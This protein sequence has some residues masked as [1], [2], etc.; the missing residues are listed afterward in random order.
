VLSLADNPL[1]F[2][3][4]KPDIHYGQAGL[5]NDSLPSADV[6][7]DL[8]SLAARINKRLLSSGARVNIQVGA[9]ST[10]LTWAGYPKLKH[11]KPALGSRKPKGMVNFEKG[12]ILP[13]SK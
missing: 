3:A 12:R 2:Q 11:Q 7:E 10:Q 5:Y 1:N 9:C 4:T 8:S 13:W 6:I